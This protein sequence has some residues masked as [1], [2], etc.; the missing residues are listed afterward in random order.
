M[1]YPVLISPSDPNNSLS[2]CILD[3]NTEN[4]PW[5]KLEMENPEDTVNIFMSMCD[6]LTCQYKDAYLQGYQD[7]QNGDASRFDLKE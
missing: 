5:M 4:N 1:I 3:T 7:A 2:L 6:I